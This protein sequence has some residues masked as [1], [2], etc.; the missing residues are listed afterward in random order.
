MGK[1]EG[2]KK[3]KILIICPELDWNISKSKQETSAAVDTDLSSKTMLS[4]HGMNLKGRSNT[5]S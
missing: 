2:G 4:Y 5:L 1:Y 3:E